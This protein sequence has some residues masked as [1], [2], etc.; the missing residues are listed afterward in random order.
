[1][2]DGEIDRC[3]AAGVVSDRNDLFEVQRLDDRFK[4]AQLLLE[5][6]AGTGRLVGGT[7]TQEIKRDDPP[8]A[9]DQIGDQVVVDF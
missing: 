9:G 4:I 3:G 1:M 8:P 7:V 6:I 5:A 2:I